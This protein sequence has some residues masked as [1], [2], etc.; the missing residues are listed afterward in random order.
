MDKLKEL[1]LELLKFLKIFA[2]SD[3]YTLHSGI[4]IDFKLSYL[5]LEFVYDFSKL[6][7]L[8]YCN[9]TLSTIS[10]PQ[11]F[12]I[13]FL[14]FFENYFSCVYVDDPFGLKGISCI[15]C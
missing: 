8:E 15:D 12:Y 1:L 9:L 13:D 7:P 11:H 10:L 4:L 14:H 3:L 5:F 6:H 2:L